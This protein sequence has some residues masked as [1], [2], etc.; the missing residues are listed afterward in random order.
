MLF[1]SNRNSHNN[2]DSSNF[3]SYASSDSFRTETGSSHTTVQNSPISYAP[4]HTG[5]NRTPNPSRFCFPPKYQRITAERS[6]FPA[7]I[8]SIRFAPEF[9]HPIS[10]E[11]RD[12]FSFACPG[13]LPLLCTFP[14]ESDPR[15]KAIRSS[16]LRGSRGLPMCQKSGRF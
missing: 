12:T 1:T 8:L 5:N 2:R 3:F 6:L 10:V 13:L 16:D 15:L 4:T 7:L 14:R 11:T 9:V